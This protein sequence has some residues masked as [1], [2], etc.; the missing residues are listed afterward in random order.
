MEQA[1]IVV[2]VVVSVVAV[3]LLLH[4]PIWHFPFSNCTNEPQKRERYPN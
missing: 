2:N 1:S 4:A 3:V